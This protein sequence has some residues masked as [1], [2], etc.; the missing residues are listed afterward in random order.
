MKSCALAGGLLKVPYDVGAKLVEREAN[1]RT[2]NI[3]KYLPGLESW[4]A[5]TELYVTEEKDGLVTVDGQ[6]SY[7]A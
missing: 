6:E 4:G 2:L 5:L 7:F 1:L 3:W